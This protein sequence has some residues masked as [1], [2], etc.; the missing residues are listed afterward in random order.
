MLAE[1]I[2]LM[3]IWKSSLLTTAPKI[4]QPDW[5]RA[6]GF[7]Q[8]QSKQRHFSRPSFLNVITKVQDWLIKV[9]DWLPIEGRKQY[10]GV[11]T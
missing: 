4:P 2:L 9:Q 3:G 7:R 10:S 1:C 8:S 6:G 5:S 11:L